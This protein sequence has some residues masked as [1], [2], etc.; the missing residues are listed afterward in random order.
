V[1]LVSASTK[2]RQMFYTQI[3]RWSFHTAWTRSG[4]SELHTSVERG[5]ETV[6][7]R[8]LKKNR[9]QLGVN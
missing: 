8:P 7:F 4:R 3:E 2:L 6:F 5:S 1:Q 9:P